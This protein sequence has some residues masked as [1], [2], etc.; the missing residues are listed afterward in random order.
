MGGAPLLPLSNKKTH[1][2]P[3]NLNTQNINNKHK[4]DYKQSEVA[5]DFNAGFTGA[6]AGL[7]TFAAMSNGDLA[8]KCAKVGDRL[9]PG[10][11]VEDFT[12]CGGESVFDGF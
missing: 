11:R 10:K 9:G 6:L 3:P 7:A 2:H 5:L 8:T 1:A 12:A 4:T